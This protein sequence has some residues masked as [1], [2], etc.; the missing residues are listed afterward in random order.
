LK[1]LSPLH[2]GSGLFCLI[3]GEVVKEAFRRDAQLVI[4]GSSLKGIFR[5]TAEAIS[6]S[7]VSKTTLRPDQLGGPGLGECN[8]LERLCV[9]CRLFGGLGYLG[10]VRFTDA[11]LH[12]D[13]QAKIRKIPALWT[14]DRDKRA[15]VY[16]NEQGKYKGRKF[17]YHGYLATG[18]EPLETVPQGTVFDFRMDV[19]SVEAAELCLLLTAMGVFGPLRPKLGGA[20]PACFGSVQVELQQARLW[21]PQKAALSYERRVMTLDTSQ[22]RQRVGSAQ[23]LIVE[24]A[25]REL[26]AIWK[27]PSSRNCPSS[28]Y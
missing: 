27:Y 17:Y 18:K 23:E 24:E 11:T 22:L 19:E 28:L 26:A 9:C 10:R 2:I 3:N 1:L 15:R 7:C 12:Q 8:N 6:R 14:P 4:P 21:Q 25:L 5:S 20:K 13:C 16:R